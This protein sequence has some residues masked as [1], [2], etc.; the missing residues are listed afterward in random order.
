MSHERT[1][2]LLAIGLQSGFQTGTSRNSGLL[3]GLDRFFDIV[4]T[5]S[6]ALPRHQ[7]IYH[8][9]R[10]IR[11]DYRVGAQLAAKHPAVVRQ[12]TARAEH[13]LQDWQGRYDLIIQIHALVAPGTDL[14][15]RRY[16]IYTDNTNMLSRRYYPPWAPLNDHQFQES[17]T[18]TRNLYRS[19][20]FVFPKS[21]FVRQSLIEDYGCAP[22]RVIAAGSGTNMIAPSLAEKDYTRQVALF[23]GTD[24]ERKGG[25]VLLQAW[26]EV[27]KQLPEAQLWIVGPRRPRTLPRS[28]IYWLG[29][30]R[31]RRLLQHCLQHATV[32]VLPSLFEPWGL[33]FQ[34]AMGHGV[35]CIGTNHCAM[36]EFITPGMNG[37][38]VPP[39]EPEPLATALI[40]LLSNP[41]RAEEMGREGYRDV[42]NQH[43]W[44]HVASRMRPYLDQA[45][46][47]L[48]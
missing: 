31:D 34:E 16:V 9:L 47:E 6:P 32:F 42:L 14:T 2:R 4:G 27:H 13:L 28:D 46:A 41:Q 8:R 18:L 44:Y 19:A 40:E 43:T 20:A 22:E 3:K 12:R 29:K 17:D 36:P 37:L 11:S 7:R 24:F 23:V 33:V 10:Y 5:L 1:G 26:G 15:Q 30:I 38:L 35:P 25:S 21:N 48:H 45:I 39:G